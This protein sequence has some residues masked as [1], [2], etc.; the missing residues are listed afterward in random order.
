MR[1]P[2]SRRPFA[3]LLPALV[4]AA[5]VATS[6]A[7]APARPGGAP[8]TLEQRLVACTTCHGS[9]GRAGTDAYYPRIAGK[10][11]E[12]L[13]NQLLNFRDGRRHYPLMA[14]L[15][16]PLPDA[17]LREIAQHFSRQDPPYP[18]PVRP[19]L[20]A[21][22]LDRGRELALS[23]DASLDV[24]ACVGCHGQA[25]TGVQPATP[26]LLGLPRDYV[27]AQFG[28]W[29]TGLR[30]A[31]EPDCMA[32]I[33][34]R[35][36]PGDVAAVSAWLSAQ[37]VP[38][39]PPAAQPRREPPM[40]CGSVPALA[41]APAPAAA[42]GS[43]MATATPA[44]AS[45]AAAA[46]QG[47]SGRAADA[48]AQGVSGPAADAS[49][50]ARRGQYLAIAGNCVGCHTT[51][52]SPAYS[53]GRG[54][55]TPFGTVYAPNLTPDP[56]TGLGRWTADE[57]WLAMHEGRS[58]DGRLLYPAFPYP[59]YTLVTREDADA[60]F[61]FLRTLAPVRRANR[62]HALRFPFDRQVVLAGW[63][64]LYFRSGTHRDDP[65]KSPQWNRGEYL[66]RGLAHCDACHGGR[67]L[68]GATTN[69]LAGGAIPMQGWYAPSLTSARQAGANGWNP[70]HLV[71]LLRTG[72]SPTGSAMGPMAEVVLR[73]TMHLEESDLR[74]IAE[75]LR[76]LPLQDRGAAPAAGERSAAPTGAPSRGSRIYEDR[77][78]DC[79]GKQGEGVSGAYPPLAGN[80]SVTLDS[81]SNAIRAVL[82][83]GFAPGSRANPRPYGMPPFAPFL[84]DEDVAAVV[85][86]IRSAWGNAAAPVAA[87]DVA[88]L[89]GTRTD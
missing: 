46:A 55:D 80:P 70:D 42:P 89:R 65:A 18:Q 66:V 56:D 79:H 12:Y 21:A 61:A 6:A 58:R 38:R 75:Y 73:S 1:D 40:P 51:R 25:L 77:C 31:A 35:L 76:S 60:I 8:A 15:L 14:G 22:T 23:G 81:P 7:A 74:A 36:G 44:G 52:G 69:G 19:S 54:I 26:G 24:P 68:L 3:R 83:G 71:A 45:S 30:R 78:A 62:A 43:S 64:A 49:A 82:S 86:H 29:K 84:G 63:R 57:F 27:N 85:T 9:E 39:T 47:V 34:R 5:A 16:D 50:Q 41:L 48:S 2:V 37:P 33:A 10:P 4:L 13:Y 88:P 32:S 72:L 53:G 20:P 17:Y 59:S 11:V 67:N 28:A 87:R